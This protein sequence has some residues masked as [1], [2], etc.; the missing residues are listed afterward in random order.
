L[1]KS[2]IKV[3]ERENDEVT[4]KLFERILSDEENH[5]KTFSNLLE[6]D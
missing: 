2:I 5:F 4:K 6:G 3:A 1:Y